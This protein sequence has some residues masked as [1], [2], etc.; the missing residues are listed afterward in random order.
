M[1]TETDLIRCTKTWNREAS[2]RGA[3]DFDLLDKRGR[4]IGYTWNITAVTVREIPDAE[5]QE[6][7]SYYRLPASDIGERFELSFRVT[8]NNQPFGASNSRQLFA[9]L[10]AARAAARDKAVAARERYAAKPQA[11]R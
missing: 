5:A 11:N 3:T 8:R 9:T 7:R 10:D 4:A 6:L 2:E 1:L